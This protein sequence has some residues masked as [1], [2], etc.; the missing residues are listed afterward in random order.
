[1][2]QKS[3]TISFQQITKTFI[4]HIHSVIVSGIHGT[5]EHNGWN[6]AFMDLI[7]SWERHIWTCIKGNSTVLNLKRVNMQYLE[8]HGF[9]KLPKVNIIPKGG[10]MAP[11]LRA[12][13]ALAEDPNQDTST[14]RVAH[15]HL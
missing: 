13:P 3:K 6:A 5:K 1:M 10:E 4:S 15:N 8:L 9:S 7:F 11:H 2:L 12:L 14:H